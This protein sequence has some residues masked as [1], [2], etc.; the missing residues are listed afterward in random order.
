MPYH[1]EGL[2][3]A[4]VCIQYIVAY[5]PYFLTLH[6]AQNLLPD[7]RL[8]QLS[9]GVAI[10]MRLV[11]VGPAL[12]TSDMAR[13]RWEAM[14]LDRGLNPYRV[15]PASLGDILTPGADF[16]A[17]YGPWLEFAHWVAYR[18]TAGAW[19]QLS[20]VVADCCILALLWRDLGRGRLT[21]FRWLLYAWS[22]LAIYEFWQ[23]GHNDAW[24]VLF[25]FLALREGNSWLW[26]AMSIGTKWWTLLL[27]PLWM[28]RYGWVRGVIALGAVGLPLLWVLQPEEWVQKVRFTTGFLGG[29]SNNAFFYHMLQNKEQAIVVLCVAAG[30]LPFLRMRT[31][32]LVLGLTTVVLA[33]SANIHPWYLSW[34][35]PGLVLTR[36]NP[37]PWLLPMA[38]MPLAYDSMLGW[39]LAGVWRED[40]SLRLLIWIPVLVHS[41]V[42]VFVRRTR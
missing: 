24:L 17:V 31:P 35:L 36:V 42:H 41:S 15:T 18:V 16:S 10:A 34:L 9:L 32:E 19:M 8:E 12:L 7:K 5:F 29:W 21:L 40:P 30:V 23:N 27:V 14:T 37:L 39:V 11:A 25:L 38:L 28:R 20:A 22:P 4:S 6:F 2:R 26:L 1:D 3:I 33:I 13:Y